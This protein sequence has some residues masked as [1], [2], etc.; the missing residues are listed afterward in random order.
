VAWLVRVKYRDDYV[1][2][3]HFCFVFLQVVQ[4]VQYRQAAAEGDNSSE[5]DVESVH[6]GRSGGRL[7]RRRRADAEEL[8]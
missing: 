6:A 4:M 8:E 5:Y 1:Y 7:G 3:T 2:M